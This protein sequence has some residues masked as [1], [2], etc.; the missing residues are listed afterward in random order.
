M[1]PLFKM[2]NYHCLNL[3]VNGKLGKPRKSIFI[4]ISF[5]TTERGCA[6]SV[7]RSTPKMLRL[8][9]D[10][11]ALLKIRTSPNKIL[12]RFGWR[13]VQFRGGIKKS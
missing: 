6:R 4:K 8:V 2:I 9:C 7:S 3:P 12:C 5:E 10:T 1:A 11:V 13:G